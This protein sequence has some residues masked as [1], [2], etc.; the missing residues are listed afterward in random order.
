MATGAWQGKQG[1]DSYRSGEPIH[2]YRHTTMEWWE[3]IPVAGL[4]VL[5]GLLVVATGL[6]WMKP[7]G[8]RPM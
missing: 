6:G 7:R 4:T 1:L 5:F 3:Q 8:E 2:T